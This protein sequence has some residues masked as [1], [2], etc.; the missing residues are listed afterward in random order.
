MSGRRDHIDIA[1]WRASEAWFGPEPAPN[2]RR[3]RLYCLPYAGGG[4][5]I[6]RSWSAL[7]PQFCV[8]PVRL[9]GR[10]MRIRDV[11][12]RTLDRIV[13]ILA[14]LLDERAA[15]SPGVPFALF[16]HSMGALIAFETTRELEQSGRAAPS[17]LCVSARHAPAAAAREDWSGVPQMDDDQFCEFLGD[18]SPINRTHLADPALRE[19]LLP[20]LRADFELCLSWRRDPA[21]RI[22]TDLLAIAGTQ[23]QHVPPQAVRPWRSATTGRFALADIPGDHFFVTAD[24]AAVTAVIADFARPDIREPG[25]Q[26]ARLS[27]LGEAT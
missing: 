13:P 20:I 3:P 26:A 17:S 8:I 24:P 22:R 1:R 27:R 11:P 6:Y 25:S 7:L 10:E 4:S 16:G 2:D 15:R 5:A 12:E 21:A 9:P 14:D 19:L 18:L 23:D